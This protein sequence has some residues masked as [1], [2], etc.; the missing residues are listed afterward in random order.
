MYIPIGNFGHFT[1]K[2]KKEQNLQYW[3]GHAHQNWFACISQPPLLAWISSQFYFLIPVDR[4]GILAV[5]K[6]NKNEQN[7]QNKW[8]HTHQNWFA[9][10]SQLPLLAWIF[11][12]NSFFDHHGLLTPMAMVWKGILAV[13]K[14]NKKWAKSPKQARPHPPKLVCIC[15]ISQIILLLPLLH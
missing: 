4:K 6:T 13:L 14:A 11:W 7:L 10:I 2:Q 3:R 12:A 5:L 1:G 8:G 15:F 9:C